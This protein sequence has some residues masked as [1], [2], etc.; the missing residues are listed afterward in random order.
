MA[1]VLL[2]DDEKSVRSTLT[3]ILQKA[4]YRVEET[5][6]GKDAIEKI[7]AHFYDLVII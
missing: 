1:D 4:G 7:K 3:I 6:D 2:I 5:G